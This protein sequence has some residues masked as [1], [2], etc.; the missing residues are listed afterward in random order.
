MTVS[1]IIAIALGWMLFNMWL[2]L[3]ALTINQEGV[4]GWDDMFWIFLSSV[5]SPITLIIIYCLIWKIKEWM[6]NER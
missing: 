2:T 5:V 6:G 4:E 1:V 3:I